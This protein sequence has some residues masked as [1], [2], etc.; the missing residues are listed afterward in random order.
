VKGR[1][2]MLTRT[3]SRVGLSAA[4]RTRTLAGGTITVFP[5]RFW[6]PAV[7]ARLSPCDCV[8]RVKP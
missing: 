3:K 6:T 1:R 8:T 5:T 7:V 2:V 4:D